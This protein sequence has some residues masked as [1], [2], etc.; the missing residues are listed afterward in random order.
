M[1]TMATTTTT[2]TTTTST[3]GSLK[4]SCAVRGICVWSMLSQLLCC[5]YHMHQF[6]YSCLQAE[7]FLG[8]GGMVAYRSC[9]VGALH[10]V[11]GYI[12]PY[13]PGVFFAAFS[14]AM[15]FYCIT[16]C[17]PKPV[18]AGGIWQCQDTSSWGDDCH[19]VC[20][21]TLGF[22]GTFLTPQMRVVQIHV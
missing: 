18:I 15:S 11:A 13:V 10:A 14:A 19:G 1:A 6:Q 20:N 9:S 21:T 7:L 2:S 12:A 16:V 4:A 3:P 8:G 17:G 5:Q 22:T